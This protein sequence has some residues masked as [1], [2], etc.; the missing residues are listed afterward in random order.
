MITF[1][2]MNAFP[3]QPVFAGKQPLEPENPV[4]PQKL[5]EAER[6]LKSALT[7]QGKLAQYT[8]EPGSDDKF[9]VSA[10]VPHLQGY[11]LLVEYMHN[12]TEGEIRQM[13]AKVP[14]MRP[15]MAKPGSYYYSAGGEVYR[16][17]VVKTEYL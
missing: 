12:A 8:G 6:T 15:D 16:V 2:A 3:R 4:D 1:S 9:T 11:N 13:M 17:A 5:M 7:V 14:G 10:V